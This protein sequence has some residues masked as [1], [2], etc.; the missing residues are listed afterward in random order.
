[1]ISST[2]APA[3]R[4]ASSAPSALSAMCL[5]GTASR[6]VRG[7]ARRPAGTARRR[8]RR[9]APSCAA[10]R[11]PAPA[12]RA[13]SP[14]AVTEHLD[15]AFGQPRRR[16][17]GPAPREP[18]SSRHTTSRPPRVRAGRRNRR[19]PGRRPRSVP[20]IVE[21]IGFDIGHDGDVRVVLQQRAVALVGLG[22]EDVA[23]AVVG[24]GARL[25]ELTA[26][27]ERR[28][29][30]AVLQ[31]TRSASRWS[32]SCR[33]CP[34]TSSVRCPRISDASTAGRSSTGISRRFASTS[35]GL[36]WGW[37]RGW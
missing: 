7:A 35:S 9:A 29:E 23:G 20:K 3:S 13:S 15:A 30:T 28:I 26:D 8:R 33:G 5:P 37:R 2:S 6:S 11:R 32:R 17:A 36:S 27:R 24:V 18:G 25:V 34:T 21:V 22:H 14:R 12:R 31:A 10:G 1:M 16:P 19:R 4:A